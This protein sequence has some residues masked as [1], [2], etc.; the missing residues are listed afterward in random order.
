MRLCSQLYSKYR[1]SLKYQGKFQTVNLLV[2][3][4][5]VRIRLPPPKPRHRAKPHDAWVF[6]SSIEDA[7]I[8]N[9]WHTVRQRFLHILQQ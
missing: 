6:R 5:M 1:F 3:P 7:R 9:N 4:S 2:V 8:I